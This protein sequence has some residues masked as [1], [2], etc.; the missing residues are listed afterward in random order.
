MIF[1]K[2]YWIAIVM[3][4]ALAMF[5]KIAFCFLIL[6]ALVFYISMESLLFLKRVEK[7][8]ISCTGI[9]K[10]YQSDSDGTKT[11]LIEFYNGDRS[12]H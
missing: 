3:V 6:G 2:K 1:I 10:E 7:E 5:I 12:N 8:G 4:F 11:P 9:I